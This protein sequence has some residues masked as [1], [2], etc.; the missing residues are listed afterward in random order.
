MGTQRLPQ[1]TGA[2]VVWAL[3]RAGWQVARITGSHHILEHPERPGRSINVPVHSRP[4]RQG[5]L[6]TILKNAELS[7]QEFRGLL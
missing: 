7:I 5:T 3:R 4:V 2:R 6:A 1:V